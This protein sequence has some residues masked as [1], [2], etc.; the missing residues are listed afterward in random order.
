M[1][2][3]RYNVSMMERISRRTFLKLSGTLFGALSLPLQRPFA[4]TTN[5]LGRVTVS[6][7]GL[8]EEPSFSASQLALIERDSVL[9]LQERLVADDG[10]AYN[11][12]W[13]RIADGYIHSGY[14]QPVRWDIQMPRADFAEDGALFEVSVPFTRSYRD[15]SPHTDPLYRLYYQSLHW[16]EALEE[17]EDERLWYRIRD[18]LLHLPYY[19]RAEH[20]RRIEPEELTPISPHVPSHEKSIEVSIAQQEMMAFEGDRIVFRTRISS[21]V[22]DRDPDGGNG[23]PTDTPTGRFYIDKKMPLRHM[24]D[25]HLTSNLEAYELPGVPWVSYFHLT[26]VAFHGTYWHCNYGR[27][28]SHGCVN[29]RPEEAKWLFRWT[30]PP[31]EHDVFMETGYGT[32][33]HVY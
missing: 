21:G 28:S 23:I 18:D 16:V 9:T 20:L 3:L 12:I 32:V 25:G 33:V 5:N 17:G 10:P 8:Y 30:N 24:G 6:W 26:G 13:Y 1:L 14:V 27:P 19:V 29:M 2:G 11:P 31:I 7:I 4:L 22:P 15:P